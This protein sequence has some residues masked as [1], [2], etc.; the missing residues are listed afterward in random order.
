[1]CLL[2]YGVVH[3]CGR[4][5]NPVIVDGQVRGGVAQGIGGALY[6]ELV[7]DE[8][9]QLISGTLADYL[10][11]SAGEVPRIDLQHMETPSTLNPLGLKGVVRAAPS[12]VPRSSPTRSS[13]AFAQPA[14]TQPMTV[15]SS[16][17]P[18]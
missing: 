2:R 18:R 15:R 11:P 10:V 12:Q 13:T 8:E 7:Y 16:A 9:G 4:V 3:D 17:G 1:V 14:P 5:I 6:E